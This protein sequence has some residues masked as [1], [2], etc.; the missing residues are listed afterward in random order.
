MRIT[1]LE[2]WTQA[3]PSKKVINKSRNEKVKRSLEESIKFPSEVNK[4]YL[5]FYLPVSIPLFD[6][7]VFDG[8]VDH[9]D[10]VDML[11]DVNTALSLCLY[12][13]QKLLLLPRLLKQPH[14]E[15]HPPFWFLKLH[16]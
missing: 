7:H 15:Y 10:L 11:S 4:D 3:T 6:N 5:Q 12:N 2:F 13:P 8:P 14:L 16:C 9:E 1:F